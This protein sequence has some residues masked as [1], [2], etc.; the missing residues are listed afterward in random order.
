[1]SLIKNVRAGVLRRPKHLLAG[2]IILMVTGMD[3]LCAFSGTESSTGNTLAYSLAPRK[4]EDFKPRLGTY[5][6][7]VKWLGIRA[8]DTTVTVA[9]NDEYYRVVA[10]TA[11]SRFIDQ[12]LK[13]R[14]RCEGL[15]RLHDF[16]PIETIL[17]FRKRS[18]HRHTKIRYL[19]DGNI[20]VTETKA[21]KKQKPRTEIKNIQ[22]EG[23][24]LEP[25]SASFLARGFNWRKGVVQ[26]LE[27]IT[28]KKRY[29]VTL[30]CLDKVQVTDGDALTEAWIIRPIVKNLNKPKSK[31]RHGSTRIYLSTDESRDLLMMKSRTLVGPVKVELERFVAQ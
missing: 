16:M 14:Y 11:T 10:D 3:C 31:P 29:L 21:K 25:F 26:Q 24:V 28:G 30:T 8:A 6:Y 5:F 4:T 2:L 7:N 19:N 22:S 1:M 17:D 15:I 20:E 23:F 9:R 12:I 13:L 27:V 18:R